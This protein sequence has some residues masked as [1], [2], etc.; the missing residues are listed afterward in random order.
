MESAQ[1]QEEAFTYAKIITQLSTLT[2][3]MH[4]AVELNVFDI[5]ANHANEPVSASQI[6]ASFPQHNVTKSPFL[7]DR[8]LSLFASFSLLNVTQ[9]S[10]SQRLYT[11]SPAG[12]YFARNNAEN[13]GSLAT[14]LL[15]SSE[16]VQRDAW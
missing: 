16:P 14:F 11:L 15:F 13:E 6:A 7:L 10:T 2:H 12:K 5:I 9:N 8:M 1:N 4:A 3:F